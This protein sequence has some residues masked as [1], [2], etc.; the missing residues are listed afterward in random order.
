LFDA[1]I[2]SPA[3]WI[4]GLGTRANATITGTLG[5]RGNYVHNVLAE[6]VCENGLIGTALF[7][8]IVYSTVVAGKRLWSQYQYD[9]TIRAAVATAIAACIYSLFLALKQGTISYPA[10]FFWWMILAKLS[11]HEERVAA[12]DSA[13]AAVA[14]DADDQE[15]DDADAM[16]PV[17]VGGDDIPGDSRGGYSL[18]Y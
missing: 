8:A 13:D 9:P 18:S 2:S 5:I 15:L 16:Q 6:V 4:Q 17:A 14:H 7:S 1:Y 12:W 10:P 11:A 3:H